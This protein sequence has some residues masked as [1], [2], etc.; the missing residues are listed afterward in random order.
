MEQAITPTQIDQA[1][2]EG[3]LFEL[4]GICDLL[5]RNLNLKELLCMVLQKSCELTWS[6]AGSIYLIE[7]DEPQATVCFTVSY[8]ASQP[9]RSLESFALPMTSTTLVGYVA[10]TG[11]IL[12]L[13]DVYQLPV[14][15]PYQHH[16]TF[17]A[18]ID[19]RTRSAL[20]LPMLDHR[21]MVIGVM[22]LLNRKINPSLTVLPE[23]VY[24][25]TKP[26]SRSEINFLRSLSSITAIAIERIQ[27]LSN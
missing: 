10:L 17:D 5:S 12:N 4:L 27:L 8:N 19:Y 15:A 13:E 1:E 6:D 18:D 23:N 7:R 21:G 11:E 24:S 16:S 14:D 22:Q 2:P 9:D 25:V 26:Y 20:V 3:L